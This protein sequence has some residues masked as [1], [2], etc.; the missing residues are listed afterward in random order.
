MYENQQYDF[1]FS[2]IDLA[3]KSKSTREGGFGQIFVIEKK[4]KGTQSDVK[5]FVIKISEIPVKKSPGC[6]NALEIKLLEEI[7][8]LDPDLSPYLRTL[9]QAISVSLLERHLSSVILG[10]ISWVK[11]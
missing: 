9:C 6:N 10:I 1:N 8:K 4:C 2:D 5:K 11:A 7:A 3:L